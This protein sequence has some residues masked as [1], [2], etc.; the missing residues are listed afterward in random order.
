MGASLETPLAGSQPLHQRR[1]LR[2]EV[3]PAVTRVGAAAKS[4]VGRNAHNRS[5]YS[6]PAAIATGPALSELRGLRLYTKETLLDIAHETNGADS[7]LKHAYDATT[8]QS[9]SAGENGEIT[10]NTFKEAMTLPAKAQWKAAS[11]KEMLSRKKSMSSTSC[12]RPLYSPDARLSAVDGFTRSRRTPH[13]RD[14]LLARMGA[15]AGH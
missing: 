9:C 11:D 4:F 13:P 2:L 5:Y 1:Q 8:I 3:T 15:I 14:A 7:A 12:R 10:P 6:H